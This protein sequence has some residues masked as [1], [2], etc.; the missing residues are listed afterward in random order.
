M[1]R[2][3]SQPEMRLRIDLEKG[4]CVMGDFTCPISLPPH[5]RDALVTGAWDTTGLLLE[6]YEEVDAV[7][8]RLPYVRGF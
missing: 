5:A 4:T 2:V 3:E 6:R 7:A 8:A 1:D